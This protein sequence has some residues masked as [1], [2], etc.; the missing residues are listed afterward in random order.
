MISDIL[1]AII[2]FLMAVLILYPTARLLMKT[3]HDWQRRPGGPGGPGGSGGGQGHGEE[4][5]RR[6]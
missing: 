2:V 5:A 6:R 4:A 1:T 3:W